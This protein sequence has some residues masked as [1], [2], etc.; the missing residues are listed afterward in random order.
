MVSGQ[1]KH[2]FADYNKYLSEL[3]NNAHTI[4]KQQA[5]N[6]EQE[7]EYLQGCLKPSGQ[8]APDEYVQKYEYD[9]AR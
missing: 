6:A 4:E 3:A 2:G 5:R 8:L 1:G 9:R 7:E